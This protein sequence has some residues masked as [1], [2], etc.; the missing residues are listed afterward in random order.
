MYSTSPN[1]RNSLNNGTNMQGLKQKINYEKGKKSWSKKSI[2]RKEPFSIKGII[3]YLLT[4]EVLVFN[5][6]L[7][8]YPQKLAS[9]LEATLG[10]YFLRLPGLCYMVFNLTTYT[11]T[12]VLENRHYVLVS[13][14]QLVVMMVWPKTWVFLHV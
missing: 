2:L 13:K 4:N 3:K 12:V 14:Q 5:Y 9:L 10:P 8:K 1:I 7:Q 11:Y 6:V